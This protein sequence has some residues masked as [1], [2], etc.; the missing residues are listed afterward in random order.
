MSKVETLIIQR[1]ENLKIL[2]EFIE[3]T[4]NKM[5]DNLKGDKQ[6]LIDYCVINPSKSELRDYSGETEISFIPMASISETGDID[7]SEYRRLTDVRSAFTY[8]RDR[9][10]VFAKISP[11]MEN[12][13]GAIMKGLKN[14]IG[15]GSTEFHVLRPIDGKSNSAWLY[16]LTKQPLFRIMAKKSMVGAAGQKRVPS[17]FIEKFKVVPPSIKLQNDFAKIVSKSEV[18]KQ[19]LKNSLAD[20]ENLYKALS[21]KIFNGEGID[22]SKIQIETS[23]QFLTPEEPFTTKLETN[24]KPFEKAI[25]ENPEKSKWETIKSF[26]KGENIPF[27]T[28]EGD[29]VIRL[30]FSKKT[31]GFTFLE[32]DEFLK[33]EGFVYNYEK[34]KDF[35]FSKLESKELVQ[36]YANKE[37]MTNNCNPQ[38]PPLQDDFAGIDGNIWYVPQQSRS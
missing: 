30:V 16:H 11:C 31:H 36:Y 33:K 25:K 6:K 15:F 17:S 29:A 26:G 3:S 4:F 19:R 2:D 13:K 38:I 21:Q 14:G 7:F 32:F 34:I 1:N 23:E 24:I 10:I 8:F 35:I 27:S 9:D 28:V 5:F 18:I 22:L 12:G 20:L 37:W